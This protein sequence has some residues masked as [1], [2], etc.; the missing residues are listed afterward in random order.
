[1]FLSIG[2]KVLRGARSSPPWRS[3]YVSVRVN[4]CAGV[5]EQTSFKTVPITIQYQ[6]SSYDNL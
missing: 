3:M 2:V 6:V 4:V 5:F 1:M